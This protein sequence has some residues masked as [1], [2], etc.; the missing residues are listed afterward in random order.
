LSA[1]LITIVRGSLYQIGHQRV[2]PEIIG[3][4]RKG[5]QQNGADLAHAE[6][7]RG[8]L[9]IRLTRYF[10]THDI[11]ACPTA[12]V[13]PYPVTQRFPDNREGTAQTSYLDWMYLT[14][15]LSLTGCPSISVPIG[16]TCDGRPVGLQLLGKPRGDFELLSA[17]RI[18]EQ[19]IG[20]IAV[21]TPASA[22]NDPMELAVTCST[23]M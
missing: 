4:I 9:F 5:L 2:C 14:F 13:A 23:D 7:L 22:A 19:L 15:V 3:D 17:A 18:L 10:E 6:R 11:L 21:R 12:S 8:E 16:T 20:D 1:N